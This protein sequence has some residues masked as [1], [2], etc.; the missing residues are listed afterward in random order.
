MLVLLILKNMASQPP[1]YLGLNSLVQEIKNATTFA[2]F[3][4]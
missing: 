2:A 1:T 3:K 4:T